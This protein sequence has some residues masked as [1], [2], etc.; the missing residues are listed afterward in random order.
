[1]QLKVRFPLLGEN[2]AVELLIKNGANV[3]VVNNVGDT[4]LHAATV[5]GEFDHFISNN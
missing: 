4:P 1:M 3:S 5:L 2:E